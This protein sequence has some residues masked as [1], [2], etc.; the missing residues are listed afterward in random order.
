MLGFERYSAISTKRNLVFQNQTNKSVARN[1]W[2]RG[3]KLRYHD[4]A[5]ISTALIG[6]PFRSARLLPSGVRIVISYCSSHCR[7]S[8]WYFCSFEMWSG[9]MGG[10][11]LALWGFGTGNS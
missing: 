3:L 2:W 8:R 10:D 11:S 9:F 6:H 7:L 4:P 1:E 5:H